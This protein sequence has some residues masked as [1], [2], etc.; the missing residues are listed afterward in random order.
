MRTKRQKIAARS[1]YDNMGAQLA[2]YGDDATQAFSE[3]EAVSEPTTILVI[4]DDSAL[5]LMTRRVVRQVIA[6]DIDINARYS[7]SQGLLVARDGKC[8]GDGEQSSSKRVYLWSF[9]AA[10]SGSPRPDCQG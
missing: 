3:M 5:R 2:R 10:A 6:D 7:S 1:V 8:T 9:W 4:Q